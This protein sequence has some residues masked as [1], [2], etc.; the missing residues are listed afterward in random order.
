MG[1]LNSKSAGEKSKTSGSKGSS[2]YYRSG[3]KHI[4]GGAKGIVSKDKTVKGWASSPKNGEGTE[5]VE[6]DANKATKVSAERFLR[7]ILEGAERFFS[8]LPDSHAVKQVITL[9]FTNSC[10]EVTRTKF[11]LKLDVITALLRSIARELKLPLVEASVPQVEER[12]M[13]D[14]FSRILLAWFSNNPSYGK[15]VPMTA[16]QE[17][18]NTLYIRYVVTKSISFEDILAYQFRWVS[19]NDAAT[20]VFNKVTEGRE[21]MTS[22]QLGK[23][24]RETQCSEITDRQVSEKVKYRFGGGIHKYNFISYHGSVLTNNAIDPSRTSDVWQDMTQSF[25]HYMV[26]CARIET[27]EDLKRV[28]ADGT[29]AL[30]LNISKGDNGKLM[31]GSCELQTVLEGVKTNGFTTNT[32]PMILCLSPG[33]PMPIPIQNEVAKMISDTL[34]SAV[35]EGLMFE[36]AMINDPKFSPGALRNKVLIMSYQSRLKPF[37]GFLVADMNKDGLGV[38]VTD[39]MEGTPASKSG[40]LKDDWLTHINGAPIQNKQHLRETL[41][42]LK[43]GD[44]FTVRRENLNEVKVVVG[45]VIDPQDTTASAALSSITFFKYSNGTEPKPWDTERVSA[46]SLA[47]TKLTRR[48][49]LTHFAFCTVNSDDVSEELPDAEGKAASLGIQFVDVDNSERCLSW[50]RGRFSDNG[51]CGYILKTDIDAAKS[52]ELSFNIIRGPR[53]LN[54]SPLTSMRVTMHGA[55]AARV[56]GSQVFFTDCN[57]ATIAVMQMTFEANGTERSFTSA[58]CPSLLRPGYRALPS[59]PTGEERAP[60]KQVHGIYCF[61]K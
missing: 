36:G 19:S 15:K 4:D 24:L 55:G 37:I 50:V 44:E 23:F 27:E 59:V 40:V 42:R 61:I 41:G 33:T 3:K 18:L 57:Q 12:A 21:S 6:S 14:G 25:T 11:R 8:N 31:V 34:E 43:V 56:S 51:R 32:Y 22:E 13:D 49:L 30:V 20:E 53:L 26:S 38:R 1:C 29:R 60:K 7:S 2:Y 54:C 39:V 58:F 45:G 28:A 5:N 46:S 10:A 48:D 52:P 47:T 17:V 16:G 35:A 9:T